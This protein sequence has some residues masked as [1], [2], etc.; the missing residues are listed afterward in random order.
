MYKYSRSSIVAGGTIG[1]NNKIY[2][3]SEISLT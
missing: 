3:F 1:Y 2:F